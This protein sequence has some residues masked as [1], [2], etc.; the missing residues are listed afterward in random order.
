MNFINKIFNG[1]DR[2]LSKLSKRAK[3]IMDL[4][5]EIQKLSD[6][7]LREKTNDFRNKVYNGEDLDNILEEA[8]AV[9]REGAHRALGMK[10]FEVQIMAGIAM[11]EGNIAEMKTGEGKTLVATLPAYLNA[12]TGEGVYVITANDYLAK[13]DREEMSKLYEFLGLSVGLVNGNM[14]MI[15]KKIAYG[16]DITYGT[17]SEFG[18][19]YLKDNMAVIKEY[20]VQTKR[21]FAIIDEVDSIL[22]DEARTPLIISGIG[23][24]PSEFYVKVNDFAKS[25][26]L[27]SDYEFG[28]EGRV[29]HL[30]DAGMDKAEV[31]F[32]LKDITD[33]SNA[34]LL[35]HIRQGLTAN[36]I[37]KKDQDYVVKNGEVVIVDKFTGR[38]MEGRTYSNGLHQAVE[39]K[40]GLNIKM[41]SKVMATIT[42][43]NYFRMFKKLAGMTGTAFTEKNEF[44]E[45]YGMD[46][47]QIPT[48]KP[49][50]RKDNDDLLFLN[51]K[52]KM[53]ALI[54]DIAKRH[55]T[56]QPVLVGTIYIDKSEDLGRL[57]E[58]KGIPHRILN[59]KQD[60]NEAEIISQAGQKGSITIATNMAGRGTDI[61]LGEG[62]AE[63]GGLYVIGTERHESRRIDNQL[64][65]RS[66]RQGDPGESRFY[67]S[68]EDSMFE[69]LDPDEK[70]R[71]E[72]IVSKIT[73]GP[74]E[75]VHDKMVS[76]AV[77]NVQNGIESIN[78]RIR[79]ATLEY[80]QIL[81][82]QRDTIYAE[83]NSILNGEDKKEFVKG[84]ILDIIDKTIERMTSGS[85]FAEE[86]DMDSLEAEMD[87]LFDT[88]GNR[89][90]SDFEDIEAVERVDLKEKAAKFAMEK[91]EDREEQIGEKEF[92]FL[93][94]LVIMKKID[95]KWVDHLDV[96]DQLRTESRFVSVGQQNP[97]RVFNQEAYD[98]FEDMLEEVKRESI[99]EIFRIDTASKESGES[100]QDISEEERVERMKALQEKYKITKRQMPI[101]DED[102]PVVSFKVD[103]NATEEI[104]VIAQLYYLEGGFEQKLEPFKAE[105][106]VKGEFEVAFDNLFK[107]K[108][109]P[110]GWYQIKL[111]VCNKEAGCI[112]FAVGARKDVSNK[113]QAPSDITVKNMGFHS[114][115]QSELN[116]ELESKIITKGN[117]RA[118]IVIGNNFANAIDFAMPAS[119]GKALMKLQRG[120]KPFKTGIYTLYIEIE[121]GK[122]LVHK[123]A[124]VNEVSK[125]QEF[126]KMMV[127]LGISEEAVK[128]GKSLRMLAEINDM[129]NNRSVIRKPMEISESGMYEIV[130]RRPK[131]GWNEGRHEFRV[132]CGNHIVVKDYFLVK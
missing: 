119:E 53:D 105:Y 88:D 89:L 24:R 109:W 61:K 65:G 37:M 121:K 106:F 40:E 47:L 91:Y 46:V 122:S 49:I 30:T 35:H 116:V 81:N 84:I 50:A 83:R 103:I 112:N 94:R 59:A 20:T 130:F 52:A 70:E 25:L 90:F 32:E 128:A 115:T 11:H 29:V 71:M 14:N 99:A 22:I 67:V 45:T 82:K 118:K 69:K 123:F 9:V 102:A 68:F 13:R 85:E 55:E 131:S 31:F 17:H 108:K 113:G 56:G 48:N 117:K 54:E 127:N 16:C 114:C 27:E 76:K 36:Y 129:D 124:V 101:V 60:A 18:F 77:E 126:L 15:Q 132:M 111:F 120:E 75:P 92:R 3:R 39:A 19:D 5:M 41:E 38:L 97:I 95:Q 12:L 74:D 6:N 42:Y 96:V 110:R 28:S 44:I 43:Q 34:E 104:D 80:D 33:A 4:E 86:W 1:Y 10:H 23:N 7:E 72:K 57:L 98:M 64:R 107:S 21:N 73:S 58:S 63:L 100:V 78:F 51:Q 93:E 87:K 62:V 79:K 2:K 26:E 66:G 125:D 8:F